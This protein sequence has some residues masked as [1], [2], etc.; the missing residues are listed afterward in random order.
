MLEMWTRLATMRPR[1]THKK[2]RNGQVLKG[3]FL[4]PSHKEVWDKLSQRSIVLAKAVL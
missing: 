4:P 2:S 3:V 1:P